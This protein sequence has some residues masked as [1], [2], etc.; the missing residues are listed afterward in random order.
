MKKH[1]EAIGTLPSEQGKGYGS[2]LLKAAFAELEAEKYYGGYFLES[3]NPRNVAFYERNEF[4]RLGAVQLSGMTVTLLVRPDMY[5]L[6]GGPPV[7]P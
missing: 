7:S 6:G 4:F 5:R 2:T 3:S 1:L